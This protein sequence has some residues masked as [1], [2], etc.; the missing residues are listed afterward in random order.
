MIYLRLGDLLTDKLILHKTFQQASEFQ[1]N[2]QK[3]YCSVTA[4][5]LGV[6]LFVLFPLMVVQESTH[7]LFI[8]TRGCGG[9]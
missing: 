2:D 4:C 7:S 6:A 1:S 9:I 3:D 8:N 5:F